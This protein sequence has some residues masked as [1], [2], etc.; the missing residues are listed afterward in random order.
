MHAL[1]VK[2]VETRQLLKANT[3]RWKK[4]CSEYYYAV[5]EIRSGHAD[6]RA[7]IHHNHHKGRKWTHIKLTSWV[8]NRYACSYSV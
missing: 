7:Q 1:G 4:A 3:S 2:G 6:E 8:N 5:K